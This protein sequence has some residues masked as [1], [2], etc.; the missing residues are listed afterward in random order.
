MLRLKLFSF[1]ALHRL[2]KAQRKP[3]PRPLRPK[4]LLTLGRMDLRTPSMGWFV[5]VPGD[6]PDSGFPES[7]DMKFILSRG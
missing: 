2:P 4:S 7:V 5:G 1:M 6:A 3:S